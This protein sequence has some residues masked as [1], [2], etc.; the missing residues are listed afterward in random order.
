[1]Y[2]AIVS[3]DDESWQRLAEAGILQGATVGMEHNNRVLR[4]PAISSAATPSEAFHQAKE[5]VTLLNGLRGLGL[6][7]K[8]RLDVAAV[9]SIDPDGRWNVFAFF[10][11]EVHMAAELAKVVITDSAGDALVIEPPVEE[12]RQLTGLWKTDARRKVL[13]IL[14][15]QPLDFKTMFVVYEEIKHELGGDRVLTDGGF[16]SKTELAR[17][18]MSANNPHAS[19]DHARHGGPGKPSGVAPMKIPEAQEFIRRLTRA[20][21][22]T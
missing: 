9:A 11:E 8:A 3:G 16:A 6:S 10:K 2:C 1:M 7:P 12:L 5:Y 18:A 15:T 22:Q 13:R 21:F 20:W 14:A 17:F 19:G 4:A